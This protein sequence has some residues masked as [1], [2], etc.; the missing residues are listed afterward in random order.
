MFLFSPMF[1]EISADS[2]L[3]L[4]ILIL[5]VHITKFLIMQFSPSFCHFIPLLFKYSP[6][7]HVLTQHQSVFFYF[8]VRDQ[9]LHL[10]E[11]MD[12]MNLYISMKNNFFFNLIFVLCVAYD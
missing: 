8:L 10:C 4:I 3:D 12:I 1:S 7:C 2:V 9:F 11:T 6:Q 5:I